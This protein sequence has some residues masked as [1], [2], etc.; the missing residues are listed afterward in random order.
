MSPAQLVRW[1][2]EGYR[3]SHASRA[4]LVIHVLTVPVF[5]LGT[6]AIACAVLTLVA[7]WWGIGGALAMGAAMALQ[8]VGHRLE[9]NA[10]APFTGFG[11]AVMRIFLE[12]WLTFPRYLLSGAWRRRPAQ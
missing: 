4:N 10:P 9:P 11:N 5:V 6:V 12:Q 7:W 2:W 8:G 1:Q 3:H